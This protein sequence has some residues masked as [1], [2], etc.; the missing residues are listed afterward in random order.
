MQRYFFSA[1]AFVIF[2]LLFPVAA[3]A[4]D[5]LRVGDQAPGFTLPAATKDSIHW[6]GVKLSD[7]VG[8]NLVILA[9][10][11]AD[12]SGGCTKEV[13]TMRDN[14]QALSDLDAQVFGISGDYVF[15]HYE[16]AKH[17]GLQFALLS[18]HDHAVAKAYQSYNAN[19]GYNRRTIFVIDR[20]GKVAYIDRNYNVGSDESFNALKTGLRGLNQ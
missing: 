5:S 3:L 20:A 8:R 10:Y 11:P 14:F 6:G 1:A 2:S 18:D 13:C 7:Y 15:S 12:W 16:W 19:S 4:Q 9:F 17:H